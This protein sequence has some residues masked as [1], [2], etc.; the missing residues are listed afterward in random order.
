MEHA[1]LHRQWLDHDAVAI[2]RVIVAIQLAYGRQCFEQG[3]V[4]EIG[5]NRAGHVG[6]HEHV[7]MRAGR[8]RRKE[9]PRRQLANG[10]IEA[11]FRLGCRRRHQRRQQGICHGARHGRRLGFHRLA[12]FIIDGVI[13]L[14]CR[15]CGTANQAQCHKGRQGF[16]HSYFLLS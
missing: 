13:S 7:V 9:L 15:R 6:M 3:D 11:L 2:D 14:S 16:F 10:N 4:P 1:G 5:G 12:H 8:D